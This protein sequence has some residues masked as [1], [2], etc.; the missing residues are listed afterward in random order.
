MG[1]ESGNASVLVMVAPRGYEKVRMMAALKD[2]KWEK[3]LAVSLESILEI[4]MVEQMVE[5][6][7][8]KM[9]VWL[10]VLM[11]VSKA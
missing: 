9:V 6:M 10:V 2:V 5:R 7:A 11:A 3:A 4:L 8:E 1:H